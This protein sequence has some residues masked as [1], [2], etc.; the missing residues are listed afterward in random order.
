MIICVR[1]QSLN[2]K[3]EKLSKRQLTVVCELAVYTL[4]LLIDILWIKSGKEAS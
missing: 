1:T 4:V 3:N 2:I